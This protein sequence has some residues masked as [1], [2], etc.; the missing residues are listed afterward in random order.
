MIALLAVGCAEP[1]IPP[2]ASSTGLTG[3][4]SLDN[5]FGNNP[6]NGNDRIFRFENTFVLTVFDPSSS[7]VAVL[8]SFPICGGAFEPVATQ[9]IMEHPDD[10][11]TGQIRQVTLADPINIF[12]VDLNQPGG[13]FG[14]QLVASGTGKV[15]LTDNDVFVFLRD[16]N[17]ANAYG[18][19]VNGQLT[20]LAGDLVH[21][22]GAV[23]VVWDGHDPSTIKVAEQFHLN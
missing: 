9:W 13:C 16:D 2:D 20:T 11:L 15:T 4:P 18:Y 1:T 12:V 6:Y 21:F 3:V 5:S 7:L 23:R 10:P 17:N 22:G 14:F 19:T 8:S